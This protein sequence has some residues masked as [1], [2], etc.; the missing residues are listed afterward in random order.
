MKFSLVFCLPLAILL[1]LTWQTAFAQNAPVFQDNTQKPAS[2]L[3]QRIDA[4]ITT[5][6]ANSDDAVRLFIEQQTADEF[7]N[8]AP[9]DEHIQAIR[10]TYQQ[11]GGLD[12]YSMRTYTPARD[13]H[14]MIVKDRLFGSWQSFSF[15]LSGP[16]QRIDRLN[17][18]P[19]RPPAEVPAEKPLTETELIAVVKDKVELLCKKDIFSGAIL[20]AKGDKVLYER[21]CGEASKAFHIPNNLDTRF[22]LGSMNKMF[23]STAVVQ[24]AEKG[25]LK[26][27]DP[28]SLYVDET[29]LPRSITSR[30]TVQHLLTHMSGLGS[31]FNETYDRTSRDLFRQVDDYKSLVQGDTLAF[32]PGSRFGYSNTGMLLLGVVI[33]KASGENYFDYIR[34]HVYEPAGMTRSDCYELDRINDN[35]AEGYLRASDGGWKNNL[36]MHVLKGGPAGGGYSTVRDLHRYARAM[37]TGKLVSA[38][39]LENMWTNHAGVGYGFGFN[40]METPN[41]KVTGHGGGFPGLNSNLEIYTSNGYIVAVMSNYDMGAEAIRSWIQSLILQRLVV[42]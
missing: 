10:G 14:V 30:V 37:Q 24:L 29:W 17:F 21:A 3:G 25:K 19:A 11:T 31:Y 1:S 34:K 7:R 8:M 9:M 38:A 20:I 28:I 23:T 36:Y 18:G 39:S 6:N 13:M 15:V 12:F 32:E 2:I 40:V 35:L 33:E 27:D 41:G 42:K 16:D 22:N 4:L 5:I 26:Y